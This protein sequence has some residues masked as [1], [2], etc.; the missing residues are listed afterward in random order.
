MR[1]F[2]WLKRNNHAEEKIIEETPAIGYQPL[3]EIAKILTDDDYKAV[4]SIKMLV[5]SPEDFKVNYH[6]WLEEMDFSIESMS[7]IIAA[8]WLTGY[9][10]PHDFGGYIDWKSEK[11]EILFSLEESI[12]NKNYV[13]NLKDIVFSDDDFNDVALFKTSNYLKE[14]GYILVNWNTDSDSYHIFVINKKDYDNLVI[15]GKEMNIRF[16]SFL[17]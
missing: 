10:T 12:K 8:Y 14:N 13:L 11:E 4:E 7:D 15:L 9:D 1:F 2:N 17:Q 5:N 16:H 6:D 3:I